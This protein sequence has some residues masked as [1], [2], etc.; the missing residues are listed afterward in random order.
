MIN[1]SE[2]FQTLELLDLK[3][4]QYCY[5]YTAKTR[6]ISARAEAVVTWVPII[7]LNIKTV[8]F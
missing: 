6:A 7:H 2:N 1:E 5:H 3:S 4:T 8:I